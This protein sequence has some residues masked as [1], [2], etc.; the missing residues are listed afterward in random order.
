ML[1]LLTDYSPSRIA[2]LLLAIEADRGQGYADAAVVGTAYDVSGN[3][4][5]VTQTVAASKPV[6]RINQGGK[7]AFE[8]DGVD[9]Y[10]E[11]TSITL[12][13]STESFTIMAVVNVPAAA[14]A[15]LVVQQLDGVGTGRGLLVVDGTVGNALEDKFGSNIGG[16]ITPS[17]NVLT[18]GADALLTVVWDLTRVSLFKNGAADGSA[19]RTAE[20]ST[21]AWRIGINKSLGQPLAQFLKALLIFNR[22]LGEDERRHAEFYLGRKHGLV[23]T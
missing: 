12:N 10:W 21:G 9:D 22:A 23:M 1:P 19:A 3:G 11:V 4:Q 5:T 17:T 16:T 8:F 7:P 13:P 20:S 2:G 14:I 15:R 6:F 18:F